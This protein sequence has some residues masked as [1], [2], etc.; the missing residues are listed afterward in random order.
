MLPT[1]TVDDRVLLRQIACL[2]RIDTHLLERLRHEAV[3][4]PQ[5]G[6][7]VAEYAQYQSGG[8]STLS[9]L[10]DSGE[11]ADVKIK[12]CAPVETALLQRMPVTRKFL[13]SL[14][15]RYMWVR[16]ARLEPNSFLWEHRDY[17][18][19]DELERHR[20][21][22]PLMTNSSAALVT[23]GAKIRLRPGRIWRLAPTHVHGACN[24][25]GPDRYHLILDCYSDDRLVEATANEWLS[26][27]DVVQL[28]V[29]TQV[30][31]DRWYVKAQSLARLGYQQ[32]AEKFL[33]RLFYERAVPEGL[34]YDMIASLY[35]SLDRPAEADQ[36]RSNKTILLGLPQ[37]E[38]Q[39]A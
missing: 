22:V 29:A 15:L 28:P 10:N 8:W 36:W 21:H 2:E 1:A 19:L 23:G 31:L 18:E 11:P 39:P 13:S 33:L 17:D 37:S 32:S 6:E 9:L 30:E 35:D 16:L 3:T 14:G 25:L 26:D 20:L 38:G 24:L 34:V 4:V 12:D 7:W 27:D 5:E